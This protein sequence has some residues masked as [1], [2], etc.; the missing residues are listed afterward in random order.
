MLNSIFLRDLMSAVHDFEVDIFKIALYNSL[1]T[2]DTIVYTPLTEVSHANY[3]A[4]GVI[5]PPTLTDIDAMQKK[6]TFPNIALPAV[7]FTVASIMLY[8]V[9]KGNKVVAILP[10]QP[11]AIDNQ[12]LTILLPDPFLTLTGAS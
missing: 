2:D 4:G 8:N 7:T 11:V 5:S 3:P 12:P 10:V 9:S 6:V 1:L